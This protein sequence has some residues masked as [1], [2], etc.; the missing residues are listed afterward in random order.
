MVDTAGH[1]ALH[2][3]RGPWIL[4]AGQT[5]E[6]AD[7][8]SGD[9][10]TETAQAVRNIAEILDSAGVPLT[11]VVR[12]TCYLARIAD[13]KQFDRAY[14]RAFG[15]SLPAR[16]TVGVA[17]LPD[18]ALVEIEATAYVDDAAGDR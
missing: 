8:L 5:G 4:V 11:A 10:E 7:G 18:G 15:A 1:Y 9:L 13:F 6:D 16:T 2:V 3:G 12:T 14:S 17:G